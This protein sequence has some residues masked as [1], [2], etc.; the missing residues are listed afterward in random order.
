MVVQYKAAKFAS[1]RYKRHILI[2]R[3]KKIAQERTRKRN[4]KG[5]IRNVELILKDI[6]KDEKVF[7][8]DL[9]RHNKNGLTKGGFTET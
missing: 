6:L 1:D 4:P 8:E 2:P 3:L 5:T 7:M 9:N